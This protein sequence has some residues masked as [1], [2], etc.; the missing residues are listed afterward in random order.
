MGCIFDGGVVIA[1]DTRAT[2]GPI[3]ADKVVNVHHLVSLGTLLTFFLLELREAPLHRAP[4]M[5]CRRRYSSRHRVY[6]RS[7]LL[8]PRTTFII[9]RAQTASGH[10]HDDVKAAPLPISRPYWC[11][12]GGCWGRPNWRRPVHC[13][14]PRQH[15]QAPLCHNGQRFPCSHGRLRDPMEAEDDEGG[16]DQA[17]I[18]CDSGWYLE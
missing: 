13:P 14:R 12:P 16:G 18:R 3:V 4:N 5:V 6:H 9:N 10:S 15:R 1:A 7:H 11:I 17:D 8:Q 2:S